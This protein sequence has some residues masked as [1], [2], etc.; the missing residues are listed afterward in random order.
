MCGRSLLSLLGAQ[1]DV[2]TM[3]WSYL[4]ILSL[5]FVMQGMILTANAT[6]K[7]R[8]KTVPMTVAAVLRTCINIP[9]DWCLIYGHWGFP[10]LSEVMRLSVMAIEQQESIT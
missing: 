4:R 1:G 3:G 10:A 7:G 8:G 6:F 2:L 5:T 9:L